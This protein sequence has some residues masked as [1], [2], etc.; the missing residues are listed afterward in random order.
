MHWKRGISL[1]ATALPSESVSKLES[2]LPTSKSHTFLLVAHCYKK[3]STNIQLVFFYLK[4]WPKMFLKVQTP[5]SIYNSS[6][7][8]RMA[9]LKYWAHLPVTLGVICN[10]CFPNL[11]FYFPQQKSWC[12]SWCPKGNKIPQMWNP[13]SFTCREHP[14]N[15]T[16]N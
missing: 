14:H 3:H 12:L 2:N 5:N 11:R 10:R 4:N 6:K 7:K 13:H 16:N 15:F 1:Q 8:F 9:T